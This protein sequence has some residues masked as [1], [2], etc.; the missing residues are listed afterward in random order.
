MWVLVTREPR[1]DAPN[2]PGRRLLS[3]LDA[4]AWPLA[5]MCALQCA[6]ASTRLFGTT[7][8]AV[9]ALFA[10]SRLRTAL[11]SNG[12]YRFTSWLFMKVFGL[13]ALVGLALKLF[14]H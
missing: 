13:V 10:L 8:A 1:P 5:A 6:P 14:L 9:L 4:L 11:W 7:G 2:W 3:A 12:Q